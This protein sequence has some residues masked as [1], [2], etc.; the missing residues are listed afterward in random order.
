MR[1]SAWCN[2]RPLKVS[3]KRWKNIGDRQKFLPGIDDPLVWLT[4][5]GLKSTWFGIFHFTFHLKRR[6]VIEWHC[7]PRISFINVTSS[8]SRLCRPSRKGLS[9]FERMALVRSLITAI[10]LD[11]PHL[12]TWVLGSWSVERQ[13]STMRIDRRVFALLVLSMYCS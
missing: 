11:K 2:Q 8:S 3:E 5:H 7:H 6:S 13:Y 9:Q 4:L 1:Y 12:P 10:I